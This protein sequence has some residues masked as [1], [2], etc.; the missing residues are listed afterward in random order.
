MTVSQ[1][2]GDE[3]PRKLYLFDSQKPLLG[4]RVMNL[5]VSPDCA[6]EAAAAAALREPEHKASDL[7]PASRH[8]FSSVDLKRGNI[9][10]PHVHAK[11][12]RQGMAT[13]PRYTHGEPG[14]MPASWVER[15][16]SIWSG[17]FS[18]LLL[19]WPLCLLWAGW[20]V[21]QGLRDRCPRLEHGGGHWSPEAKG[22][23]SSPHPQDHNGWRRGGGLPGEGGGVLTEV[24]KV[25]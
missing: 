7:R 4:E 17:R 15:E 18:V 5:R 2:V 22:P 1:T 25:H 21:L 19:P 20:R 23:A 11:E 10:R 16:H 13:L 9:R 6:D 12:E 8:T 24:T 14:T 3:T